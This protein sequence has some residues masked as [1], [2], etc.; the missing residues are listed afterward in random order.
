MDTIPQDAE[1]HVET[2]NVIRSR[3]TLRWE[4]GDLRPGEEAKLRYF[5]ADGKPVGSS[6]IT[7]KGGG[8][9]I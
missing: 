3:N 4:I 2:M 1:L 9:S 8:K 5:V 7:W 6:Q